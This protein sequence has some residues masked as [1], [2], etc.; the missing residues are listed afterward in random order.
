M[1]RL[2]RY[3]N[4]WAAVTGTGPCRKRRALG[5][6]REEAERIIH[7]LNN[8]KPRHVTVQWLWDA[9][10]KEKAGRPVL[11]TM[12]HTAKALMPVFGHHDPEEITHEQC[13]DYIEGRRRRGNRDGTI[14][15]QM[16]H[17]ST[18]LNWA[19]KRRHIFRAPHITGPTKPVPKDLHINR[20]ED[21]SL[22]D[23]ATAPHFRLAII[24]LL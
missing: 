14:Y 17:L 5:Q 11:E 19:A 16:G 8:P 9:Y 2:G 4:Q 3:R 22:L 12:K 23:A 1:W 13:L 18:V 21:R 20:D 24:L 7:R 6:D 15:T 10:V